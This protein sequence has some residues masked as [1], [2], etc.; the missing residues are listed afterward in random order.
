MHSYISTLFLV[1][2]LL[3]KSKLYPILLMH[4]SQLGVRNKVKV[5][6]VLFITIIII[7]YKIY[8]FIIVQ[9]IDI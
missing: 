6:W 1:T 4:I 9:L 8:M 5:V 7:T 3:I 2:V